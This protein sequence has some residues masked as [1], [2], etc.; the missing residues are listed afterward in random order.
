MEFKDIFDIDLYLFNPKIFYNGDWLFDGDYGLTS[1]NNILV[2]NAKV[3]K[4][5][6][7]YLNFLEEEYFKP[8]KQIFN[9][10]SLAYSLFPKI[11]FC[12]DDKTKKRTVSFNYTIYSSQ[13]VSSLI[14]ADT[15]GNSSVFQRFINNITEREFCTKD[16][17][18]IYTK[19]LIREEMNACRDVLNKGYKSEY[20]NKAYQHYKG[21]LDILK[22]HKIYELERFIRIE[23]DT[24]AK[25]NIRAQDVLDFFRKK[26]NT[27]KLSEAF[28]YDKLCLL[29]AYSALLQCHTMLEIDK[30]DE[31]AIS[32]LYLKNY[33]DTVNK[34]RKQ[35][36]DYNVSITIFND[37]GKK[38]KYYINDL[39]K[40]YYSLLSKHPN[41]HFFVIKD[42]E[43]D[44]LFNRFNVKKNDD[45]D[46]S[47]A[48]DFELVEQLYEKMKLQKQLAAS[49]EFL[50]AGN[51]EKSLE[52]EE[53]TKRNNQ[54]SGIDNDEAARRMVIGKQFIETNS[55]IRY[56]YVLH[57]INTFAGYIGYIYP[58]GA[59]VFEKYYENEKKC[60]IAQGSATYVMGIYNFLELSK[61][62]KTDIIK[63]LH[64]DPSLNVKRI[65][66]RENMD[67]WKS[68]L[69]QAITGSDYTEEII[70]YIESLTNTNELLTDKNKEL[71]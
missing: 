65:F 55:G 16:E 31:I 45:F 6:N 14:L 63:K 19:E 47:N 1:T 30:S 64:N 35:N 25:L 29:A 24:L 44:E 39:E 7:M 46:L 32:M 41:F 26:I 43:I 49:W 4:G 67:K 69:M 23:L 61:L 13:V 66:H 27:D 48:D 3:I 15:M 54:S 28:D 70:D 11:V 22:N 59:V 21:D 56:L 58:N 37:K 17:L 36:P 20:F 53:E 50:P 62:S 71:K 10:N 8:M 40:A 2:E 52:D 60:R 5:K 68:E 57:G 33:L 18:M 51:R 34:Y 42:N 12:V 9:L 38:E